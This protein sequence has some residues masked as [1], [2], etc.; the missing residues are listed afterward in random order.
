MVEE[1]VGVKDRIRSVPDFPAPGILFRDITPVLGAP[2]LLRQSVEALTGYAR[3]R[4]A[5]VIAGIESR[6]F[7]FGVPVALALGVP[8]VPIRKAGK[9]PADT[10]SAEYAL[11]YGTAKIEMH[12]DAFGPGRRVVIVDDLLATGGTAAAAAQL[13]SQLE[14]EVAGMA[15]LIELVSLNGR[16]RL[17]AWDVASFVRY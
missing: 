6:G 10:V 5:E 13:V 11:E 3:S 14:G 8:F 15:F 7:V 9:L 1:L 16:S 17:T 4:R 2:E 12:R